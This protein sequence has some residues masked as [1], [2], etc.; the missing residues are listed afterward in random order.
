MRKTLIFVITI[1]LAFLVSLQNANAATKSRTALS[2]YVQTDGD[3]TYTF[4]GIS[5]PSLNTAATQI[6]MTVATIGLD[7][8][9]PS[10]TFTIGSG[11]TYRIFIVS[12]NHS[13]INSLTVTGDRVVF[14]STTTGA[15]GS[16]HLLVTSSTFGPTAQALQANSFGGSRFDNLNQLSMWG[17]IVVP[18]SSTGFAMEFV[19]DAHDSAI[20]ISTTRIAADFS[21]N[22]FQAGRGVN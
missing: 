17:A 22:A 4:V 2:P 21:A 8:A 14:M 1:L 11:E 3:S 9:N 12:T 15:S 10:T 20:N 13:T 7:G 6:G 5:H 16:G 18:S 19:G